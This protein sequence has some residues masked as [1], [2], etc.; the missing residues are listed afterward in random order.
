MGRYAWSIAGLL[1]VV[2]FTASNWKSYVTGRRAAENAH[3]KQ[4]AQT[5]QLYRERE[6]KLLAEKNEIEVRYEQI[7]RR[8]ARSAADAQ[9]ELVRLRSTLSLGERP[10]SA[11]STASPGPH[12]SAGIERELL[13]QCAAA[14]VGMAAQ[15]DRLEA[16]IVGLQGYVTNVCQRA[17]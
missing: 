10:A 2:L 11:D 17:E 3:A 15:A 4:V 5:A 7:K 12:G 6:Q 14:L 16:R 1:L 8:N 13:G 9:S